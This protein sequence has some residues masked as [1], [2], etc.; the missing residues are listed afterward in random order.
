[1][2]TLEDFLSFLFID[3]FLSLSYVPFGAT[4]AKRTFNPIIIRATKYYTGIETM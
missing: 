1:M 3:K 2:R 4:G